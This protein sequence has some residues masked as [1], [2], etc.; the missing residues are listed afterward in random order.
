MNPNQ[1][2]PSPLSEEKRQI[3]K[4]VGG[5]EFKNNYQ[6]YNEKSQSTKTPTQAFDISQLQTNDDNPSIRISDENDSV[7]SS[8][9]KLYS[10]EFDDDSSSG[11]G[12]K[13][14]KNLGRTSG[15]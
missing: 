8:L 7:K 11:D 13:N 9:R 5:L 1:K 15:N 12:T 10:Y 2:T 14:E 6:D 4:D 3:D